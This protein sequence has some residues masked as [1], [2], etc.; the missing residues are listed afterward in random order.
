M[1]GILPAVPSRSRRRRHRRRS[2]ASPSRKGAFDEERDPTAQRTES[3]RSKPDAV[4]RELETDAAD[5]GAECEANLPGERGQ[6]H[7]ASEEPRL[8]EIG[9]ERGLNGAVETLADGE[10]DHRGGKQPHCG[11]RR[12]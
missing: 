7:I 12:G 4:R 5:R 10:E 9:D 3:C 11:L 1:F 8:R 2:T 6:G